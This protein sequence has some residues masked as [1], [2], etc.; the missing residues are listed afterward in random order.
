MVN[1][2]FPLSLTVIGNVTSSSP[3]RSSNNK[4]ACL[5]TTLSPEKVSIAVNVNFNVPPSTKSTAFGSGA[6]SL[7]LGHQHVILPPTMLNYIER[8]H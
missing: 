4:C 7:R 3:F 8:E 2:A 5:G 1:P 6:G